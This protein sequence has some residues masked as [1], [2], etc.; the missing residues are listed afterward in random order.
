MRSSRKQGKS[1]HRPGTGCLLYRTCCK[2][3]SANWTLKIDQK[4]SI[5]FLFLRHARVA[6]LNHEYSTHASYSSSPPATPA[7]K[8]NYSALNIG[9]AAALS[10]HKISISFC[11]KQIDTHTHRRNK[12]DTFHQHGS[13]RPYQMQIYIHAY[14]SDHP[15]APTS[16]SC[17]RSDFRF[18][19]LSKAA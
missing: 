5:V 12:N 18:S 17:P 6:T 2:Q 1:S 14:F 11:K 3:T 10:V 7:S 8:Y 16:T 9:T 4:Y 15:S 13:K 19:T